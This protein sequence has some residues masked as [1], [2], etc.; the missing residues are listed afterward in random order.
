[1]TLQLTSKFLSTHIS[2]LVPFFSL[3]PIVVCPCFTFRTRQWEDWRN[4]LYGTEASGGPLTN[5]HKL[6][7]SAVTKIHQCPSQIWEPIR[8]YWRS[9]RSSV[10]SRCGL[11]L[12]ETNA[13]LSTV[14]GTSS[15]VFGDN[16]LFLSEECAI[17]T[18]TVNQ[19][20]RKY[21]FF[22]I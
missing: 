15:M 12:D 16:K 20:R 1:M 17:Y 21:E 11:T 2:P 10:Q 14:N 7:Q 9:G 22:I 6:I 18:D 8:D 19:Q 13:L 4:A 3:S 5:V